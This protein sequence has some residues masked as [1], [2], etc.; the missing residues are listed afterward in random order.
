VVALSRQVK[1]LKE[2]LQ[3]TTRDC[4]TGALGASALGGSGRGGAGRVRAR[5]EGGWMVALVSR[6]VKQLEDS[7]EALQTT[8]G[9]CVNDALAGWALC[10]AM[11]CAVCPTV[12]QG[13]VEASSSSI[14]GACMEVL[15]QHMHSSAAPHPILLRT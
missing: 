8:T 6:Q 10:C 15:H 2:A 14:R 12:H 1:Q 9:D 5:R 11:L 4:I 3:T 7:G 13:A